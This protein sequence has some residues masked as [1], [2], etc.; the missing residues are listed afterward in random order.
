MALMF[1]TAAR[2]ETPPPAGIYSF[3]SEFSIEGCSE[4]D[5]GRGVAPVCKKTENRVYQKG[6]LLAVDD[7]FWDDGTRSWGAKVVFLSQNRSVPMK[8]LKETKLPPD[9]CE[10][11]RSNYDKI[12]GGIFRGCVKPSDCVMVP[13]Q[14]SSCQPKSAFS[15]EMRGRYRREDLEQQRRLGHLACKW[16]EPPC[17]AVPDE[18]ICH[19][20]LCSTVETFFRK[21]PQGFP[22]QFIDAK[23][24]AL[25]MNQKVLIRSGSRRLELATDGLGKV[26]VPR[27]H[28]DEPITLE[29]NG[30]NVP[31]LSQKKRTEILSIPNGQ[32]RF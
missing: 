24:G 18:V 11:L 31:E 25:R 12:L 16:V 29:I 14:W 9:A 23:T 7:F 13:M 10:N 1:S 3:V 2:A 32:V 27:S 20:S 5:G 28:L 6:E 22:M 26:T 21:S 17:A 15:K 8:Y 4:Y 19:N 30:N